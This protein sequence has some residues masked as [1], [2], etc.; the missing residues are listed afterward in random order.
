MSVDAESQD[1]TATASPCSSLIP[2]LRCS[3]TAPT[4]SI[5]DSAYFSLSV[6]A[7]QQ[8]NPENVVPGWRFCISFSN[9]KKR[10]V[11]GRQK[12]GG[13][14]L[15]VK[16]GQPTFRGASRFTAQRLNLTTSKRQIFQKPNPRRRKL[17]LERKRAV[18]FQSNKGKDL[19]VFTEHPCT[20]AC[21]RLSSKLPGRN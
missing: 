2:C 14:R 4:T 5:P 11:C 3:T 20:K 17:N 18:V 7:Q 1:V 10:R 8:Y 15:G 6:N 19:R 13:I 21:A 12:W 9:F 16:T